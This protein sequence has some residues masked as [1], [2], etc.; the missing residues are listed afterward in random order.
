MEASGRIPM[1]LVTDINHESGKGFQSQRS[2][3]QI[4][5]SPSNL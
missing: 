1:K 3:V 5:S 4:T 2:N